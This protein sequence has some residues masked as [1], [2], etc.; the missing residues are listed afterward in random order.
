M[1]IWKIYKLYRQ[2]SVRKPDDQI[3]QE[4]TKL[5]H[6]L[7]DGKKDKQKII[8]TIRDIQKL[9]ETLPSGLNRYGDSM[10]AAV[11]LGAYTLERPHQINHPYKKKNE[12]GLIYILSSPDRPS[13]I[14]LGAT[15]MDIY[16]RC[17]NY[18]SKYGYE[19][20]PEKFM[21]V[22]KP[23]GLE[24]TVSSQVKEYRVAGNVSGDSI[25]WYKLLPMELWNLI[26]EANLQ[27]QV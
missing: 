11:H 2:R 8:S 22:L 25:E 6:S 21:T 10:E 9:E 7:F 3:R 19:V 24:R 17:A 15:T 16:D 4:I 18:K 5:C 27:R 26:L 1:D 12:S 23:F 13:Q 20:K 14:K